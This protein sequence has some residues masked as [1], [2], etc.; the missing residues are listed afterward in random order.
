MS[1]TAQVQIQKKDVQAKLDSYVAGYAPNA[2]DALKQG[3][4]K[5]SYIDWNTLLYD[6]YPALGFDDESDT[7]YY[8]ENGNCLITRPNVT[9]LQGEGFGVTVEYIAIFPVVWNGKSYS[10]LEIPVTVTSYYKMK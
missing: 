6:T 10:N 7:H 9:V 1:L 5:D 2:Y 4:S 8:Y 3:S